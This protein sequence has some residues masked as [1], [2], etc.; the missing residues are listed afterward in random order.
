MLIMSSLF[1]W[2]PKGTKPRRATIRRVNQETS[3]T[4][5]SDLI[6]DILTHS[7]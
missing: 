5:I 3:K 4:R 1:L 2:H 6:L 7:R